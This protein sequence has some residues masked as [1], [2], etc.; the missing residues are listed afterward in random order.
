MEMRVIPR[1]VHCIPPLI[2]LYAQM[3]KEVEYIKGYLGGHE[4]KVTYLYVK[5]IE[6]IACYGLQT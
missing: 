4:V 6:D 5:V 2:P 3:H 1:A